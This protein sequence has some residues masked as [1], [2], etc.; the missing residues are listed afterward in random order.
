MCEANKMEDTTKEKCCRGNELYG[1][2][3]LS[4]SFTFI[5]TAYLAIQNLQSSLNQ[6]D[7]LGVISLSCLYAMIIVS[8]ILAPAIIR[9]IGFNWSLIA[10][11]IC[12]IIYTATNFYPTFATLVPSSVLLGITAG[13]MWTGQSVYLANKAYS[14]AQITSK[15]PHAI[16]SIYN[17]IFFCMFETTQITGNIVSSLVLH[18]GT[19]NETFN[20]LCGKD[21]CPVLTNSSR[22]VEPERY[23][24]YTLLG[25]FLAFD[26]VGLLISA[27]LLPPLNQSVDYVKQGCVKQSLISCGKALG[28]LDLL[29]LVPLILF[30]AME[31]AI[32]WTD[33]TK[34]YISCPFGIQQIGFI[35]AAYGG[36]TTV[37]ALLFSRLAEYSGR[38]VLFGM[39]AA[40]NMAIFI[41]LFYFDPWIAN[42]S[43]IFVIAVIWGASEGIWQTQSNALIALLFPEKKE[44]AFANYHTWKAIGF[45]ITF[46]Y[47]NFLCVS[48]KLY[49]A[50]AL[51]AVAVLLYTIV[52]IRVRRRRRSQDIVSS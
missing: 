26:I 44:S 47:G 9:V 30:M 20:T 1:T 8:G 10:S 24:V 27:F 43:N 32:L 39:A 3:I 45:T 14:Y 17:G 41:S 36:S 19:Y 34:S 51:L 15:D 16:L 22:I 11:F 12:H 7:G 6:V 33:F 25:V 4:L 13:P 23:I 5:F 42:Q 2:V 29:L 35:M 31:Q 18:Q 52:E 50:I 38:Y 49:I 46:V 48:S 28:D 37:F 21:D 40:I